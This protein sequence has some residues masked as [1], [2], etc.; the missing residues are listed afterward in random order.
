[1]FQHWQIKILLI[2]LLS[3]IVVCHPAQKDYEALA[4]AITTEAK[5]NLQQNLMA[6]M[7]EG[8]TALALPFCK[9]NALGFTNTFGNEHS[10]RLRRLTNKPRNE[11]NWLTKEETDI[12]LEIQKEKSKEGVYPNRMISSNNLVTV[13]V[14]IVI[15]GQCLQCHGKTSDISKETSAILAKHYP[16]DKAIGYEVGELRGLFSVEFLK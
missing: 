12:F 3:F 8:G 10:V 13:Y 15:M 2:I 7:K 14:P 11:L 4:I 16:N 9:E 6:K 5:S 1:M